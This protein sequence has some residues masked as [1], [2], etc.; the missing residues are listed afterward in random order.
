MG[1][2]VAML[3]KDKEL[4]MLVLRVLIR[5]SNRGYSV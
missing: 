2:I 1:C 5:D 4:G 3:N